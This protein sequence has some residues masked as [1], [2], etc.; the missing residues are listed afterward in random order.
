MTGVEF[1]AGAVAHFAERLADHRA[2]A[3]FADQDLAD[4]LL[5]G[6]AQLFPALLA[7]EALEVEG[8]LRREVL[9]DVE[10]REHRAVLVGQAERVVEGMAGL[11]GEIGGEEDLAELRKLDVH[12]VL[13]PA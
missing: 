5:V 7:D 6:L 4:L 11:L 9:H 8:L 13:L 2:F 10:D 1:L 12:G 3:L